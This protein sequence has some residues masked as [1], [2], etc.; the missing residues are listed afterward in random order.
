MCKIVKAEGCQ[1]YLLNDLWSP[2]VML[3]TVVEFDFENKTYGKGAALT[4]V[5][6]SARQSR[7]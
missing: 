3:F 7:I 2:T 4:K 5:V 6:N 1:T